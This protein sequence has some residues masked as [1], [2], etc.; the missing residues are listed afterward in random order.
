MLLS[1]RYG[2]SDWF[3]SCSLISFICRQESSESRGWIFVKFGDGC[4]FVYGA[5]LHSMGV[6]PQNWV[7]V[8]HFVST[9]TTSTAED[10]QMMRI[11]FV[12]I[13]V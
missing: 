6:V 11:L 12:K 13:V 4:R 3:D 8:S 7:S 2:L 9:S 5:T 1:T 10:G